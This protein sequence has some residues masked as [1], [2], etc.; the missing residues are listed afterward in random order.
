MTAHLCISIR[1]KDHPIQATKAQR[2]SRGIALHFHDLGTYM[3]GGW[4]APRPGRFTPGKDAVPIVQEAGW[5]P[6]PVWT[7]AENL[8]PTGIR[9]S[10]RPARHCKYNCFIGVCSINCVHVHFSF[11]GSEIFVSVPVR[12]K[13]VR[14]WLKEWRLPINNEFCWFLRN[15]C[16]RI[17]KLLIISVGII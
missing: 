16:H 6:G 12:P 8:A 15:L 3:V 11:S 9:P 1:L 7:V 2:L 14:V 5:A 13:H 10:D 17:R 4:L